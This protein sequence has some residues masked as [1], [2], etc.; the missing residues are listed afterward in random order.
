S[1]VAWSRVAEHG[2]NILISRRQMISVRP[3]NVSHARQ[4]QPGVNA[5]R[6]SPANHGPDANPRRNGFG[7]GRRVFRI[8]D[9]RLEGDAII[10]NRIDIETAKIL[11]QL[12]AVERTSSQISNKSVENQRLGT[13]CGSGGR[14][15]ESPLHTQPPR[16]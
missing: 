16:V 1:L 15:F 2:S 13:D 10:S 3:S 5:L 14:W 6:I 7:A 9:F 11:H 8:Q 4:D 12:A